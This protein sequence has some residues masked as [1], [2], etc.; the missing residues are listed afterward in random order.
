M[1]AT[2]SSSQH[3]LHGCSAIA[4]SSTS[5]KRGMFMQ[6]L[7][8]KM[9]EQR[10]RELAEQASAHAEETVHYYMGQFDGLTWEAKILKARDLK[11]AELIVRECAWMAKD[12]APSV[13]DHDAYKLG[14]RCAGIDVL[15]HFGVE[16]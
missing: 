9:N 8:N 7:G 15:K 6:L 10:I 3:V 4:G 1:D 11:F 5:V 16:E 12:P 13:H 14:R 2:M